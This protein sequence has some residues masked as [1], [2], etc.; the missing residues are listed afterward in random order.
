[1]SW[2]GFERCLGVAWLP[3]NDGQAYHVTP[4]DH[5]GPTA[6]G[7]TFTTF[8][9]WRLK[10]G[11]FAPSLDDFRWAPTD[12]LANLLHAEFWL[13][14]AGD[15]LQVG[16][17]LIMFEIALGSG[18]GR[19]AQLLKRTLGISE[20]YRLD[21]ATIRTALAANTIGLIR[22][23]N[24]THLAFVDSLDGAHLFGRG[25]DRRIKNDGDTAIG[26]ATEGAGND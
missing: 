25:W 26:W 20:N 13:P 7:V 15:R 24:E 4:G 18:P 11:K 5:G 21:P 1:M 2:A 10:H 12:E 8:T 22:R 19:A 14:V 3:Q 17:D 6:W 23:L 16:V 9:A